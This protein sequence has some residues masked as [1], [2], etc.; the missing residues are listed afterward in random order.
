MLHTISFD[1]YRACFSSSSALFEVQAV[2]YLTEECAGYWKKSDEYVL[3]LQWGLVLVVSWGEGAVGSV[4]QRGR[5]R[6]WEVVRDLQT[7]MD[8]EIL[9]DWGRTPGSSVNTL[10]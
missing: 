4:D 5:R 10:S 6:D 1:R 7:E 2:H 8:W 9:R 3:H